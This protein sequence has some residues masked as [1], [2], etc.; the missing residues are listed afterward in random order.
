[1]FWYKN[2]IE[3][4]FLLASCF[5]NLHVVKLMCHLK[6]LELHGAGYNAFAFTPVIT[7]YIIFSILIDFSISKPM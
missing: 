1:M 5:I 6:P 7:L 4:F 2:E 3:I